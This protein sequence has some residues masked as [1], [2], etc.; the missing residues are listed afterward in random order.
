MV[1]WMNR[2]TP[3]CPS[4]RWN[5]SSELS[6]CTS[7]SMATSR[8]TPGLGRRRSCSKMKSLRRLWRGSPLLPHLVIFRPRTRC[9]SPSPILS[10][11]VRQEGG[12]KLLF[13]DP[14]FSI[15]AGHN[16]FGCEVE[17]QSGRT[18]NRY[19]II[20][21]VQIILVEPSPHKIGWGVVTFSSLIQDTELECDAA[22][23]HVLSV[24]VYK[25]GDRASLTIR[26]LLAENGGA[27]GATNSPAPNVFPR[28]NAKLRFP[29]SL[30]CTTVHNLVSRY[31][32]KIRTVKQEKLKQ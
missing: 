7:V 3:R 10:T 24:V 12:S 25:S 29:T 4:L 8:C 21:D 17:H 28:M 14:F 11:P 32:E 16:I 9:S 22:D 20:S 18:E 15:L 1:G 2:P 19:I 26:R 27:S 6:L 31:W 5:S 30:Q 23:P 13:I